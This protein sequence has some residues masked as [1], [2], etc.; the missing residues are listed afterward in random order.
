MV[1]I[2]IITCVIT[3]M[4]VIVISAYCAYRTVRNMEAVVINN[5]ETVVTEDIRLD[6]ICNKY[7]KLTNLE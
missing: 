2:V 5:K 7:L 6:D 4:T 3:C 1:N